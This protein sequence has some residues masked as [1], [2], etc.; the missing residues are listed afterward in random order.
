MVR[1]NLYLTCSHDITENYIV[2]KIWYKN[3]ENGMITYGKHRT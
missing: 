3:K 1:L 2:K